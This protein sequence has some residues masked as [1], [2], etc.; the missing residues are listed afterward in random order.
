M[1]V[2]DGPLGIANMDPFSISVGVASLI[3]IIFKTTVAIRS[4]TK[5]AHGAKTEIS[6]VRLQLA[7]LEGILKHIQ[8]EAD[9]ES[10]ISTP[11][12]EK[13]YPIINEC[14]EILSRIKSILDDCNGRF[15][16][17]RWALD[18][19]ARVH[20]ES[21]LLDDNIRILELIL[22]RTTG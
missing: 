14:M 17:G 18:L 20:E 22:N 21:E 6:R 13:T 15:G 2:E 5:K 1:Q 11:L 19:S 3:D 4:F 8:N 10:E 16:P 7:Q 12:K 9:V